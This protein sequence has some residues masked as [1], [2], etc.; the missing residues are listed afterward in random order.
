V[1]GPK[2]FDAQEHLSEFMLAV[3]RA[4]P[5]GNASL[6][7]LH[8]RYLSWC[9]SRSMQPLSAPAFG[10]QFRSIIDSA[11]LECSPSQG[12]VIVHGAKLLG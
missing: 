5:D 4:D 10:R 1:A 12:D 9:A 2:R 8:R 7:E 6:R 11:G 3:A